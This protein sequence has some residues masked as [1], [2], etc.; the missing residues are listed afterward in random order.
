MLGITPPGYNTAQSID[1]HDATYLP[2]SH[3]EPGRPSRDRSLA[4][5]LEPI[6]GSLGHGMPLVSLAGSDTKTTRYDHP[7]T[8]R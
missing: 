1:L 3:P 2:A 6:V 7:I 8:L 4:L 5:V